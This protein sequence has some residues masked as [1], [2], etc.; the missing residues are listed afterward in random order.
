MH[1]LTVGVFHTR[2]PRRIIGVCEITEPELREVEPGH[3]IRCHI[4]I[5]ELRRLQA[6]ATE[7]GDAAP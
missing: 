4:P 5:D 7:T 6:R 3:L 2:C 1:R